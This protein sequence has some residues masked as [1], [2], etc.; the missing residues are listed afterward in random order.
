MLFLLVI[1]NT[2]VAEIP[3]ITVA[4][5]NPEIMKYTPPADA[6]YLFYERPLCINTV[7]V[8]PAG[9]PTPGI[10][11]KAVKELV[12]MPVMVVRSGSIIAPNLPYIHI[13]DQPG[14]NIVNVT[15]IKDLDA[16]MNNAKILA[17]Q[18]NQNE[19]MIAES[20]P[21][22]TTTAQ[23]VLT[24]LGYNAQVSSADI[25]NPISLKKEIV[26]KAMS[27]LKFPIT[28]KTA[29][30]ELGD[31]MMAFIN[32]FV[33]EFEGSVYLAGG[34][35]M[36]AVAALLK[37]QGIKVKK[38]TTTRYITEDKL[39]SFKK[40]AAEIGAEYYSAPL[41]FSRSKYKGLRD[42]E[43]GMVKEGVGAGGAVYIAEKNGISISKITERV[44]QL[45]SK[46]F[47]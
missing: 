10:I 33:P 36:L 20:I 5:E 46:F 13:T 27:R 43:S 6:E 45:Y 25:E 39:S 30:K 14:E 41:N 3:G 19:I 40:T 12:N 16:I 7:P 17:K 22:G 29:L 9:H 4:G 26:K 11:T 47:K 23:A 37:E 15:A 42:Y 38:I 18:V 44:E 31:P 28:W 2:N 8:T 32:G 34:T 1:S 35:Q 21:G 24:A